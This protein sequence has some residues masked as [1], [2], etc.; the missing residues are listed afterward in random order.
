MGGNLRLTNDP[1]QAS[2]YERWAADA[3][4]LGLDSRA[5]SRAEVASILPGVGEKW[6]LGIFTASDGQAYPGATCRAYSAAF[7]PKVAPS[8]TPWG[9]S[10]ITSATDRTS[11]GRSDSSARSSSSF[12]RLLVA[13]T[14]VSRCETRRA[15]TWRNWATW[16]NHFFARRWKGSRR[17]KSA[18]EPR[19]STA[20]LA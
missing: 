20:S 19:R 16:R 18:V 4:S 1:E 10:R 2:R 5:V 6:L 12:P 15:P 14:S 3:A 17:S 11:T 7:S 13:T 9:G 8:S